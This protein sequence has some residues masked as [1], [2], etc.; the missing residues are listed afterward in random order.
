MTAS[1]TFEGLFTAGGVE[2]IFIEGDQ[3]TYFEDGRLR[4]LVE[5][6]SEAGNHPTAD[7]RRHTAAQTQRELP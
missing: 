7:G 1:V 6:T 5:P 4:R 3:V 2:D